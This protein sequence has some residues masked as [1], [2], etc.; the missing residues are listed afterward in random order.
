MLNIAWD[1]E[2]ATRAVKWYKNGT[3]FHTHPNFYSGTAGTSEDFYFTEIG[4]ATGTGTYLYA[5]SWSGLLNGFKVYGKS[6]TASEIAQNYN[7]QKSRFG[8]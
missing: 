6:L 3:L 2:G 5:K 1:P 8:L 4:R 7:A